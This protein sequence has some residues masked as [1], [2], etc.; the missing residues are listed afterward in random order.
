MVGSAVEVTVD[1]IAVRREVMH[2]ADR[3]AQKRQSRGAPPVAL[4]G[5]CLPVWIGDAK[6][7]LGELSSSSLPAWCEFLCAGYIWLS[8]STPAGC[9]L[10]SVL[11][12]DIG[13]Y[14]SLK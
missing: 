4:A 12:I 14:Y 9:W 8:I 10:D 11:M 6:A 5:C 3:I 13:R 7:A 1:S 2:K